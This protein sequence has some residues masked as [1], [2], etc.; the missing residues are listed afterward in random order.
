M[1]L[2]SHQ[3]VRLAG[4]ERRAP[5]LSGPTIS[6]RVEGCDAEHHHL[7][8]SHD[9]GVEVRTT[10][11]S[12]TVTSP[13]GLWIPV[14][15]PYSVEGTAPWRTARFVAGTCPASWRRIATITLDDVVGPM[16]THLHRHPRRSWSRDLLSAVVA[17]LEEQFLRRPLPL[18]FPTDHRAREVAEALIDDPASSWDLRDWAEQVGASE[19][20][21]RRLFTEQTGMPFRSW[22]AKAR[23]QAATRL[24]TSG[25]S[26][27][28]VA[29]RCGYSSTDAFTRAFTTDAGMS[30]T[31]YLARRGADEVGANWPVMSTAWPVTP[32][33]LGQAAVERLDDCAGDEMTETGRR[34]LLLA[35]ATMLLA[36]ACGNDDGSADP[37]E[38]ASGPSADQRPGDEQPTGTSAGTTGEGDARF[39]EATLELDGYPSL[40]EPPVLFD[41]LE[42]TDD[43]VTVRHLYGE[44]TIPRN[45]Q[46]IV[47]AYGSAEALITLGFDPIAYPAW[48]D[49]PPVLR[50]QAPDIEWLRIADTTPN[51]EAIAALEPDLIID[52]NAWM[53][54]GGAA[55]DYERVSQIAPTLVAYTFPVYWQSYLTQLG[56]LFDR[57][58][59][60]EAAIADYD[61]RIGSFRS[62]ASQSITPDETVT[63]LLFFG[64]EPW[65]YAP[66]ESFDGRT[67][68]SYSVA[69]L[70]RELGLT[71]G[72]WMTDVYARGGEEPGFLPLSEEL[73]PEIE[74][75]HL[76]VF[77]N[78][79][80]GQSTVPDEYV[81]F[82]DGA[83]GNASPAVESDN[84]H[85]IVDVG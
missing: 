25:R 13:I 10:Q 56:E 11:L 2:S 15:H 29:R 9:A 36:A 31:R 43:T 60:A 63:P 46:R 77:P 45:P 59:E 35:V 40:S 58:E 65:L 76:V 6:D 44:V 64:E 22:R 1:A 66:V 57:N 71:P 69:W 14:G 50:E 16:L 5:D 75:D 21:L 42:R 62:E 28:E 52:W 78:G 72:P 24:L 41:I 19:R 68:P 73:L 85:E 38:T 23:L 74:A 54:G 37:P 79:Y 7:V 26:V 33:L 70:Y 34:V 49:V 18:R 82:T 84:V 51:L 55:A 83:L 81:G 3:G 30:P 39:D 53:G 4:I 48:D 17:H 32:N 67:I 61:A 8:W 12:I 27:S 20:T 80:S 47:A